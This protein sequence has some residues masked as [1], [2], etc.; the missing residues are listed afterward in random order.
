M[1]KSAK[2]TKRKKKINLNQLT[3]EFGKIIKIPKSEVKRKV[4]EMIASENI[5]ENCPCCGHKGFVLACHSRCEN[6]GFKLA[7]SD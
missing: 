1:R 2:K 5:S 6:C 4:N 3:F 7:C